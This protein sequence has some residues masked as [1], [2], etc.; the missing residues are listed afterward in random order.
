MFVAKRRLTD[1]ILDLDTLEVLDRVASEGSLS[2]A[3][4]VLGI[5]QQAVSARVR[6]AERAVGQPLVSR[7]ATGSVMTETGRLILALATP[8]LEASHR[9]EASLAALSRPAGTLVVAASQT[10]AELFL[11]DWLLTFHARAP[12]VS[13]RLIAG[14]SAL[15]TDLVRSGAAHLGFVEGPTVA[16][17]LSSSVIV[18][19]ELVVV[20]APD[21]PWAARGVIDIEE[22]ART[23]LLV[24]EEGSGTRATLEAWLEDSGFALPAPAAVLETTAIIRANARAGIAPA[25]MSL[26]II[27][28]DA[29]DGT[30]VRIP[31]VGRPLV[32]PLRAIW[33]GEAP[34]VVRE[35][36]AIAHGGH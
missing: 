4:D 30:L 22:L 24:R 5:T 12:E 34:A 31:V 6:A 23:P 18:E 10:I 2:R 1:R 8:V 15:V 36:L 29:R 27:E 19:D 28:A 25:V 21:H 26:R 13:V 20:T 16:P 9:L 11:P 17:E 14:N 35:F 3:A 33:S 7:S 32:R